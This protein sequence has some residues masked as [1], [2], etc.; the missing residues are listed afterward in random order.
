MQPLLGFWQHS[1][2]PCSLMQFISLALPAC[3][4]GP[5]R[6]HLASDTLRDDVQTMP[7]PLS[8]MVQGHG[9]KELQQLLQAAQ[10]QAA[11]QQ[12]RADALAAQVGWVE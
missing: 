6:A 1:C 4:G 3:D 12:Q 9:M 5:P 7:D 10:E 2:F 8:Q 11:A